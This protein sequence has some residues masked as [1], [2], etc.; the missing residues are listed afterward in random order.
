MTVAEL[1]KKTLHS[2]ENMETFTIAIFTEGPTLYAKI[3]RYIFTDSYS[4]PGRTVPGQFLQ[5][6]EDGEKFC[7]TG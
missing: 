2:I 7:V 3:H 4:L 1:R 6:A 5:R